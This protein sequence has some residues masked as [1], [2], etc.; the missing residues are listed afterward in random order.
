MFE[1]L[2]E[3][4]MNMQMLQPFYVRKFTCLY[5]GHSFSTLRV[6]SRF[7]IPYKI[8]S[9]FCP[10]FREGNYNPHYYFVNV[11]PECG[12]AFTEEFTEKFPLGT[13]ELIRVKINDQWDKR[14]LGQERDLHQAI[15]SYKLAIYAG[16]LKKE[17][18][19][20]MA[21]LCLRLAWI[22]RA[23]NNS[24]QEERFLTLAL[25][26][27]EE[28]FMLSDFTGTSMS[29]MKVLYLCGELSRRLSQFN[30]A[31][32]YFSRVTEHPSRKDE[33][34]MVNMAREQWTMTVE[35][36]RSHKNRE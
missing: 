4:V 26:E 18:H 33:P 16:T 30:K 34:K 25:H 2:S 8:D 12:F 29:E 17:R 5:C 27:Y 22:Y 35:E 14:D 28:S 10:H 19:A 20:A 15:D 13:K 24:E 21:G 31:I 7:S 36:N 9:D 6:R 11:C 1:R 32:S 3:R 23:E